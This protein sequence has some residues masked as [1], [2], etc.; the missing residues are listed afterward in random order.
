L[1]IL[2]LGA[3]G[4]IGHKIYQVLNSEF[5]DVWAHLRKPLKSYHFKKI[6][7]SNKVIENLDLSDFT[8]LKNQ[9]NQLNP[10]I[11]IN[12]AG[13]TIRR[14][15]N[16]S[17]TKTITINSLLPHFLEDWVSNNK[18][19]R[20]IHFC[21]DCVFSGLDG[22][23]RED[24][25]KDAHDIYGKSKSLGEVVGPQSLTIRSSMIGRELD[26]YTEL[27][28]WFLSQKGNTVNGFTNAIYSGITTFK[29]AK[30]IKHIINNYPALS[31]LY[32]VSS[33]PIS[34]YKLL[35]LLNIKF[36]NNVEIIEEPSYISK[37]DL[38]SNKFFSKLGIIQPEWKELLN[39]LKEDSTLNIEYY[40]K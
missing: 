12:A 13:I 27:L 40:K 29:M 17:I 7:K 21:T 1:K 24:S 11:I 28:E 38:V 33:I 14:G 6:Y 16:L 5:D 31:G 10:D 37:K 34:K 18:K 39:E 35:K 8:K 2:I 26:Y 19:R 30:Y 32:N 9:L 20:L 3:N 15:I 22:K 4:M 23:Y 25:L 36:D